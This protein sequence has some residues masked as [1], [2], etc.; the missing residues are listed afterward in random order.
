[1]GQKIKTIF[2]VIAFSFLYLLVIPQ[3]FYANTGEISGTIEKVSS[4]TDFH[5]QNEEFDLMIKKDTYFYVK[6]I[7]NNTTI[8]IGN[9]EVNIED[10]SN[11]DILE[12]VEISALTIDNNIGTLTLKNESAL[13]ADQKLNEQKGTLWTL[14][15]LPVFAEG[16]NYLKVKIGYSFFYIPK[17]NVNYVK[18]EEL[19]QPDSEITEELNQPDSEIIEEVDQ[20]GSKT[21]EDTNQIETETTHLSPRNEKGV[22][23]ESTNQTVQTTTVQFD[24]YFKVTTDNLSV[25]DNSTGGL[26]KV[27]KL[28]NGQVYPIDAKLGNWHRIK[29]GSGYGYVW[30]DATQPADSSNLK[31]LNQGEGN[32]GKIV[33]ALN[34]LSVY[35]NSSGKLVPIG[36]IDVG[37]EYP[38]IDEI[39]S[40]YK[41]DFAGRIG[42]IYAP[43]T[44]LNFS[45]SDKYFKVVENDVSVYDNSTG[46]LVKVGELLKGQT[47]LIDAFMGNWHRIKFGNG[48]GYVWKEATIPSIA[49]EIKNLNNGLKN[50]TRTFTTKQELSIYDNSSGSL[51]SF[52]KMNKGLTY[53]LISIHG[54]WVKIDYAGRIGYVYEPA[55]QL[56]FTSSDKYFQVKEENVTVYD[57]SGGTLKPVGSLINKQFYPRLKDYGNW[58]QIKYGNS[59]A[60]VWKGA[61]QVVLQNPKINNENINKIPDSNKT[62]ITKKDVEVYDNSTG[63]LISFGIIKENKKYPIIADYGNWLQV[64]FS[65]RIGYVYKPAVQ[66]G[67]IYRY[68]YYN[69]TLQDFVEVQK[70]LNPPPQTDLYRNEKAFVHSSFVDIVDRGVTT[71]SGVRFR[72]KPYLQDDYIYGTYPN[73]TTFIIKNIVKGDSVSGND[74]WYEIEYEGEILYIHSSIASV[75][76]VA[77]AKSSVK[78]Y[79]EPSLSSH[80]YGSFSSG[81]VGYNVKS[82]VTGTTV[83]GSSKWYEIGY[84]TWRNAKQ[85]D[86]VPYL[87]PSKNDVFQ[88]LVLNKS[89]GISVEQ[90]NTILSGKGILHEKGHAFIEAGE[91]HSVNE[92]YLI[93]HALL[94]TGQGTS[95][96]AAGVKVGKDKNGNPVLVTTEN[97]SQLTEIKKV[98]NMYGIGAYDTDPLK[99]GAIRAY[100]EGWDNPEK[101]IIG[102]AAFIS[103]GYFER[104]QNT[105]YK[106]RWNYAYPN[107]YGSYP[108]YATDMGWALKQ[109][110]RIK[111]LYEMIENPILEF[112]IVKL[113]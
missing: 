15:E 63:K 52:G 45:T 12:T 35:D 34:T 106:M 10:P 23:V 7:D 50:S 19:N 102:G 9:D 46:S 100:K 80:V 99:L 87:D 30:K 113:K 40:W 67:P 89:T 90:A 44:K 110:P 58:H 29:F 5:L 2:C 81:N 56:N 18:N 49:G 97:Q 57:N 75:T 60:Y 101:A 77:V 4:I 84:V 24:K 88:H 27:G 55:V 69:I 65:G 42:Y 105:L 6:R 8:N 93:A 43:A 33:K 32:N 76:K 47:Y 41:I 54:N 72:T 11:L 83:N 3:P 107:S 1:M 73:G 48:Y 28:V 13:Y 104:G 74:T 92:I 38:I 79:E 112:D 98:Y 108:Q 20:P 71:T 103:R 78:V 51:V 39:G 95:P 68:S 16:D 22:E 21:A 96:L 14:K 26:V 59:V 94:E 66:I 36:F 91:I 64:D 70:K 62:F 61:T 37:V 17:N 53:P 111:Q 86:F 109:I 85:E 82:E 25:Y 31:N